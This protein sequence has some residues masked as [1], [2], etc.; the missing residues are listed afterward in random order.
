MGDV[1]RQR[2]LLRAY[3]PIR[4][5]ERGWSLTRDESGRL[6]R[7]VTALAEGTRIL[8]HLAD[9]DASSVV[10]RVQREPTVTAGRPVTEGAEMGGPNHE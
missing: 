5:L 8:T 4:Q 7:S 9:G 2:Q 1:T 6:V 10:D 3:D